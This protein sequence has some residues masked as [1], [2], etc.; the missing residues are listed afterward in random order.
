MGNQIN[1]DPVHPEFREA[2]ISLLQSEGLPVSDL[3]L[4]L[5]HF[6]MATDNGMIIGGIGLEIYESNGLLRSLI[7]KREYRGMQI[8]AGLVQEIEQRAKNA[9]LHTMYLL[10]ETA[11]D[12][13][14]KKGYEIVNR[15]DA[16]ES[17]QRSTEFSHVCPTT[18][19]L[20]KKEIQVS[21][22]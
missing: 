7:V 8:A 13:F 1:I 20:I 16:P 5:S 14:S 4:D 17:L 6:L 18:A 2:L 3:P 10:T 22:N 11:Q 12:Y 15:S 9:G 21:S 19:V